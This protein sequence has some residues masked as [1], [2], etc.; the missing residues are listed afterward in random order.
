MDDIRCPA[1]FLH[2]F[3][4]SSGKEDCTFV[5]ISEESAFCIAEDTLAVE[6]VF[7]VDEIYLHTGSSG[8]YLD[9]QR[10]VDIVDHDVHSRKSD[11]FMELVL[12][13]IDAAISWYE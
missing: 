11:D 8:C 2:C 7:I 10:S 3:Q 4:D 1:L 12:P 13:F 9:D 6:V 5:V